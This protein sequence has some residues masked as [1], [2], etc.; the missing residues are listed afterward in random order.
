MRVD[1][2][3]VFIH[4]SGV[5]VGRFSEGNKIDPGVY[6]V[7]VI[8]NQKS[9]G[10]YNVTFKDI[11]GSSSAQPHFTLK[12]LNQIG[13]RLNANNDQSS[14]L[15][16]E[17]TDEYF[18]IKQVIKKSAVHYNSGD[19]ELSITVPQVNII[20]RPRGYIDPNRWDAGVP[21]IFL[22]YNS[23]MYRGFTGA[24]HGE[25]LKNVIYTGNLGMK[26]GINLKG[27][28]FRKRMNVNLS[29]RGESYTQNLVGY[30]QTDITRLQSQL[31][32]GDSN[33]RG[34]VFDSYNIRGIV[35]Q[36]DER[37]L[38]EGLRN[39]VP[40]LRGVAETN[41][42]VT[43]IQRG[44]T[45]YETVVPPGPFELSDIGAMGYGG[46]LQ[47]TITESDGRVRNQS[48]PFS[49][50]PM[51]L[52]QGV[53]LFSFSA[54]ELREDSLRKNPKIMQGIYQYG[55]GNMYTLYGGGQFAENYYS[56]A[57]GNAFNTPIG[58]FSLDVTN[59]TSKLA[60]NKKKTGTSFRVGYSRYMEATDTDVTLAAY[61]YSTEGYFTFRE[62]SMERYYRRN[63]LETDYRAKERVSMTIGQRLINDAY[64]NFTG[65]MYKYWDHRSGTR[66][67]SVTYNKSEKYFS[68]SL[69]AMRSK[70]NNRENENT[71]MLSFSIPFGGG[72]TKKP[73]FNS[74]YTS[75]THDEG[76]GTSL[77]VNAN[78]SQGEMSEL[79]YGIGA[80]TE[81]KRHNNGAQQSV[82]GNAFYRSP[83]GNFGITASADSKSTN[84]VSLSASGSVVG[85][86]G[87]VTVGPPVGDSPFAIVSV[88]G[89]KGAK[90]LNGYGAEVNSS[91]Y[92]IM[93]SLTSYRENTISIDT[94]GLPGTVD[95]LDSESTIVPRAGSAILVNMK[96]IVG[97]PYILIVRRSDNSYLPIGTELFDM[98]GVSQGIIGQGGM[99]FVR[100]WDPTI[101]VLRAKWNEGREQC[102]ILPNKYLTPPIKDSG[103][104]VTMEVKCI[105]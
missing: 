77:Q 59:A 97:S 44:Q 4:G 20:N 33:T 63:I 48:I 92:A 102:Q 11:E 21:T 1:Y 17:K 18:S 83:L 98:N 89:G 2:N 5:D 36:S 75:L 67:Y 24:K 65:S 3:P 70:N 82:S 81:S 66:Q 31:T 95:V 41:A 99:A 43:I 94:R 84:Q 73:V 93:P 68:Y 79:T 54:G 57:L 61:R 26:A 72:Y 60:D 88:P 29:S 64:L 14:Q 34:E 35:L 58:G 45:V 78:G 91:G 25:R 42:K 9:L 62:A 23:N 80:T 53:S 12:E 37:M 38:P 39:Y 86:Q 47:M 101:N 52:H 100:G 16:D 69:T 90:I 10:K 50:P 15:V 87:G 19:Y 13:I 22:D 32:I 96:T 105:I 104:I 103:D 85:H 74:L 71:Y 76:K 49:A 40:I 30:A 46:D 51:L 8:V 7:F 28:R 6:S 55:V 27:W 56:L